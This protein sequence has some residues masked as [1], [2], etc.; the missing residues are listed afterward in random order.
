MI[1][2]KFIP[3]PIVLLYPSLIHETAAIVTSWH[4]RNWDLCAR[5]EWG[6]PSRSTWIRTYLKD[7]MSMTHE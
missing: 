3:K 2:S 4:T 6:E 5:M 7:S 1:T